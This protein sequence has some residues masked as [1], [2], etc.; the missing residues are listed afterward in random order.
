MMDFA[1]SEMQQDPFLTTKLYI[2]RTRRRNLVPRPRLT[3]QL[4]RSLECTLTLISAPAGFG[5]TTLLSEWIDQIKDEGR[6][7]KDE[8]HRFSFHPSSPAPVGF[9]LHPSRVA[10]LSLDEGDNDPARFLSYIIAA[11]QTI[12]AGVGE[13]TL[14]T[15]QSE[16][17]QPASLESLLTTL[18]N[19]ITT[20]PDD[21]VLVLDDY[22]LI[23]NQRTHDSL[24]FLLNHLPPPM[25]LII[26][27]RSNPPLPLARLRACGQLVELRTADLRFTPDEAATFL[28]QVM[29]L[30]LSAADLA[31]LEART[32]GWIVG[33]QLAALSMQ[34]RQDISS[35]I[36]TFSGS[37]RYILD[38]LAEE[39][40]QRQ[41]KRIQTFLLQTSILNRLTG[42]LCNAVTGQGD[43]QTTLASLER[44]NLFII[45]LD[46]ERRWY[47]Y[48]HLLADYLRDQLQRQIDTPGIVDL[49]RR[50]AAWYEQ[51]GLAAEAV[52]H[53]LAIADVER[54]ARLVEQSGRTMLKR[55]EMATLLNW[56]EALPE[57]LVRTR[58]RLSL[59]HAWA[60]A[61]T[62]QLEAVEARLSDF[63]HAPDGFSVSDLGLAIV[64][65]AE[66]Q[67]STS[68]IL[69]EMIAIRGT[70]AY[71]RRDM[72]RAAKLFRQAF[73]RLPE[74]NLFLRGA[75]ALSLATA[76]N[77][78][79]DGAGARWAFA[80]ASTI[81]EANGNIHMTL[82][83]TWNLARLHVEQGQLQRA[84]ELYRQAMQLA[85]RQTEEEAQP[86]IA[87]R[88]YVGLGEVLY[89]WNYLDEA[90]RHLLA[91][92]KLGQQ[93]GDAP[94]LMNGYVALARVKQAQGDLAGAFKMIDQAETLRQ[95]N[96]WSS[97]DVRLAACQ[98]RLW[99][100]QGNLAAAARWAQK[101]SLSL[102]P[103]S[104]DDSA[105]Q[106]DTLRQ[107]AG[108]TEA[109]LLIAH[110]RNGP[111]QPLLQEAVTLLASLLQ[112]AEEAEQMERVIEILALQ[113]LAYQAQ[114][115]PASAITTLERALR[116]AEPA[117]YIRL[118]V[119]EGPPMAELLHQAAVHGMLPNYAGK[120]LAA[121]G[122]ERTGDEGGRMK[123]ALAASPFHP[124]SPV[125]TGLSPQPL[126]ES[127]S[128]RE[129]EV[130]DLIATG[131]SNQQ[132]ADEL[133][134]TVGTVKWHVNNIYGKLGVRRR[135]QAVARAR[136][137]KLL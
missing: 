65:Q 37:H 15:L 52:G 103:H 115:D 96:D 112:A 81:S 13:T 104:A 90:S 116:L 74:E 23:N 28:N 99:L 121:F 82:I 106:V 10:W 35:F 46:D 108:I 93:S 42:P 51:N 3:V 97:W 92:I 79:G 101:S 102:N 64:D 114:A 9:I 49:H 16:R 41:P 137:L 126:V 68:E 128:E 94:T 91:G 17:P 6:G 127:L 14:S 105:G 7:M 123:E 119:D 50:A 134:L 2:P 25:H 78:M 11:L 87:G 24:I 130:L 8:S 75:V 98:A 43:A 12:Q 72:P 62:G 5:K 53:A 84:A 122:S 117:G 18:I 66:N 36:A 70:V 136:E 113:A 133:C 69:G 124:S 26:A 80:Q 31:T 32:E 71:Y 100:R 22:H 21:F 135:T 59:F 125:P 30:N 4:N 47:R 67:N 73:E 89:Q 27:S 77:L 118:F 56:L 85:V 132:I 111:G 48:H 107:V 20:I 19:E 86:L 76:C 54:A 61:L 63:S 1:S 95:K 129:L 39:V 55:S 57:E 109:R 120:L 33:L 38:Y 110:S 83:A 131:M 58:P 88:T 29:G 45:P 44:A 40:L 34:D 60:L